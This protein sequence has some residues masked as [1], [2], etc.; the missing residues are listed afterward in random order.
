M[1]IADAKIKITEIQNS[2]GRL[3][4]GAE[5]TEERVR[6]REGR[7]VEFTPFKPQRKTEGKTHR[8][9]G[10]CGTI[11]KEVTFVSLKSGKKRTPKLSSKYS[12]K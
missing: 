7:S 1:E 12:K 4:I 10:A 8:V 2:L 6:E 5:V 3:K 11:T 9:S